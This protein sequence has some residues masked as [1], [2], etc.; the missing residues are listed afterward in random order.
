MA[1]IDN[2]RTPTTEE[3]RAIGRKGGLASAKA[4]RE[5]KNMREALEILLSMPLDNKAVSDLEKVKGF[6]N[7]KGK[8][9]TVQ[10]A[11]LIAQVQ[12]ALKGDKGAAEYVRDTAGQKPVEKQNVTMNVPVVFGGE[13]EIE[14]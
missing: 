3:A 4:R 13:D 8:N 2:L 1:G 14:D 7:L 10:D 6:K 12:K 11:I 5:K 9:V